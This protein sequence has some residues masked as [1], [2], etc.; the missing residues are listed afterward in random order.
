M[1]RYFIITGESSG[2]RLGALLAS[3]L[4]SQGHKVKGWGGNAMETSG[5]E[6]IQDID[7]L[8]VMGWTDVISNI[9]KFTRLLKKCKRDI[10]NYDPIRIILIDFGSFN[11][12]I[13]KWASDKGI[14]VT[15]YSPPK[16]NKKTKS[17]LRSSH[18]SISI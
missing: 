8:K 4:L 9:P 3:E 1:A 16:E 17:L 13:A 2:D 14:A 12:R 5:V 7:S 15:Y 11:L 10:S 18:S 6:V